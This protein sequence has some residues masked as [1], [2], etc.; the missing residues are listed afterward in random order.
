MSMFIDEESGAIIAAVVNELRQFDP[1]HNWRALDVETFWR[2][3]IKE[4]NR[5]NRP[6]RS[7]DVL[8]FKPRRSP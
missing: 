1:P 7:A 3:C 2:A 8:P 6:P 5:R 4:I